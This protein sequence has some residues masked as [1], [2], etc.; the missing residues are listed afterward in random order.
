[1]LKLRSRY[2]WPES[3]CLKGSEQIFIAA[4]K[5]RMGN[6]FSHSIKMLQ[7]ARWQVVGKKYMVR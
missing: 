5:T 6:P 3:V 4:K 2:L 7:W 1:M